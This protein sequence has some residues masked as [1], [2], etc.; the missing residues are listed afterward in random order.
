MK[1]FVQV[2]VEAGAIGKPLADYHFQNEF[3]VKY[4]REPMEITFLCRQA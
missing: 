3:T 4:E 2:G 1:R